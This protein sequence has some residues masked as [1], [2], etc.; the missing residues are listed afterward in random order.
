LA[1]LEFTQV[2]LR[3]TARTP[4]DLKLFLPQWE[5]DERDLT[6]LPD[7]S[8]ATDVALGDALETRPAV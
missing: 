1:F 5:L 3:V 8:C 7:C 4:R 6:V 2:A